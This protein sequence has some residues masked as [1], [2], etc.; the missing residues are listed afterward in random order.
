MHVPQRS[1]MARMMATDAAAMS[2]AELSELEGQ[3]KAQGDEVRAAKE[4]LKAGTGDKSTVDAAVAALL[5]LKAKL[6]AD[7]AAEAKKKSGAEAKKKKATGGKGGGKKAAAADDGL[8]MERENFLSKIMKADLESGKHSS[9]VTRF[10]PEPNGY[11][12]I[13][14]AK[15]ICVNFGLGEQFGGTTFMRFDDTNPEKEEQEYIDA[16]Q[17]DVQWLGFDWKVPE[18]L[19]YASD[20][21]DQFYDNALTLIKEGKAYVESLTAEEM[22]E[23]RGSLKVPGRDSPYRSRSVEENLALFESMRAGEVADGEACLR[24]KIDMTSGN[25]NLRDPTIYR[26]KRNAPHPRTGTKWKIYPMY[27]PSLTIAPPPPPLSPRSPSSL[28]PS[29][30]LLL[31]SHPSSPTPSLLFTGMTTRTC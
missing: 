2:P 5:E 21:F 31:F 24:L 25:M 8:A 20:Y 13:G 16:I 15:S 12:H 6:P 28:T 4:A 7:P 18:R 29:L 14:H 17:K 9:V 11:L 23:Y 10:P 27:M 22:R 30:L 1:L 19:T 3:I 26:I